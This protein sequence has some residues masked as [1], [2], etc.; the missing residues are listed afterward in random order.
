MAKPG[1]APK[2]WS[3]EEEALHAASSSYKGPGCCE[4]FKFTIWV[5]VVAALVRLPRLHAAQQCS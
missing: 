1:P 5:G 2:L 3:E 4:K